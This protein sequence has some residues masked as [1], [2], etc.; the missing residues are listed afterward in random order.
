[1][2]NGSAVRVTFPSFWRVWRDVLEAMAR[3]GTVL[4]VEGERDRRS[5]GQLG[6]DRAIELVHRGERLADVAHRLSTSTRHVIVLT[7]W[8]LAGGHLAHRLEQ[9]LDDG[10]L[11]VDLDLRR[12][13]GVALRGEVV[14]LEGLG[15]WARRRA[16]ESGTPLE[17][18]LADPDRDLTE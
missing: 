3:P 11:A 15:G 8:D 18:W 17:E 6:I 2:S 9:L 1:M 10:R 16:E 5:V 4:L 7:D 14:H 12:R 13:L